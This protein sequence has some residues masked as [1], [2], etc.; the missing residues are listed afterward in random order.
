MNTEPDANALASL[1]DP[2]RP[3]YRRPL[4]VL[5][6]A[7]LALH[8]LGILLF[9]PLAR[10][11]MAFDVSEN[12]ARAE[13]VA[14]REMEREERV[15]KERASLRIPEENREA[16]QKE[17]ARKKQAE[18]REKLKKM[19]EDRQLALEQREQAFEAMNK[20]KKEDFN[21]MNILE[22]LAEVLA[23]T[24]EKVDGFVEAKAPEDKSE[25]D[26]QLDQK[27]EELT[28]K[29][30]ADL[31]ALAENLDAPA[32]LL[33][34]MLETA[35]ALKHVAGQGRDRGGDTHEPSWE[36]A[37]QSNQIQ[38]ALK[39]AMSEAAEADRLNDTSAA[40]EIAGLPEAVESLAEH[41]GDS[42]EGGAP[43]VADL[44]EAAATIESQVEQASRDTRAAELAMSSGRSFAAS[45]EKLT[46]W[47]PQRPDLA[48]ALRDNP[49]ENIGDLN[50]FRES[51]AQA[52]SQVNSMALRTQAMTGQMSNLVARH[53][54][55]G[56]TLP[57]ALAS[58]VGTLGQTDSQQAGEGSGSGD[59][60]FGKRVLDVGAN[61]WGRFHLEANAELPEKV[62]AAQALP[63]RMF[64]DASER[65]GWLYID[66][67][68]AIGPW[69]NKAHVAFKEPRPPEQI[70][71]FDAVYHDGKFSDKP[72]HPDRELR[73]Q[74]LQTDEIRVQPPR[75]YG[76]STY[77]FYTEVFF[78]RDRE[79]M[80]ATAADD[81]MKMWVNGK[82][83]VHA[84]GQTAYRMGETLLPV[85]FQAGYNTILVRLENAPG[86]TMFSVLMCPRE[87][88]EK[89]RVASGTTP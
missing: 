76:S 22:P 72:D 14:Q 5:I 7:S 66:T 57:A 70:I 13:A 32:D 49:T 19:I 63:G 50:A 21:R 4:P 46:E 20:R 83:M 81:A 39:A 2:P 37:N 56:R 52:A 45:K 61:A 44:Y 1:Y 67:W 10:T 48:A 12:E 42:S 36:L 47:S 9:L 78:D 51:V 71:D 6:V 40:E 11:T 88:V 79:M 82:E 25:K 26:L 55:E 43:T 29:L 54:P 62:I 77:F 35:E 65:K 15:R 33:A 59:S 17:A 73:W 58:A 86:P 28:A 75:V 84:P 23:Q 16:L 31:E 3:W 27:A 80:L 87:A 89:Y 8:A 85:T 53:T 68:Y 18:I 34:N 38:N 74:F 60:S 69:E 30:E 24:Q 41:G 64:T